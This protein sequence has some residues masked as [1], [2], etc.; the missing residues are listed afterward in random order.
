MK[1]N[2]LLLLLLA[3]GAGWI[4]WKLYQSDLQLK[5]MQA[6]LPPGAISL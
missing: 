1:F 2:D 4:V 5:A 6:T 3:G